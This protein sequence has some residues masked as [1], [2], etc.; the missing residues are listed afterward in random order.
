MKYFLRNTD[1]N[2]PE[3]VLRFDLSTVTDCFTLVFAFWTLATNTAVVAHLSFQTLSRIGPFVVV[4]AVICVPPHRK[5]T[6]LILSNAIQTQ[7]QLSNWKWLVAAIAII[8]LR[9]LG[10]PLFWVAAF[11]FLVVSAAKLREGHV[12]SEKAPTSYLPVDSDCAHVTCAR[13]GCSGVRRS[14]A[15]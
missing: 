9:P 11:F 1:S 6:S 8:A 15:R 5:T 7:A 13:I 3:G 4:A 2:R 12:P 14:Q 10:Y